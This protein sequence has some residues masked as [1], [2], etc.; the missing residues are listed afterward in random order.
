MMGGI[1]AEAVTKGLRRVGIR[2]DSIGLQWYWE[3]SY[4]IDTFPKNSQGKMMEQRERQLCF[5][6]GEA[7]IPVGCSQSYNLATEQLL[8]GQSHLKA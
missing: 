3:K 1:K 6:E 2:R 8:R 7:A 4:G 5:G